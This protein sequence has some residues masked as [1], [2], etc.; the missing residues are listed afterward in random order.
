MNDLTAEDGRLLALARDGHEPTDVD[1]GRMRARLVAELGVGTGFVVT[2]AATSTSAA[3]AGT[4]GALSSG[5]AGAGIA[6]G[7]SFA[8][9]GAPAT[10]A[11]AKVISIILLGT[12]VGGGGVATYHAVS[13]RR[14]GESSR[15][16]MQ[17]LGTAHARRINPPGRADQP[18]TRAN[19][20]EALAQRTFAARATAGDPPPARAA[21]VVT[22]RSETTTSRTA[23]DDAPASPRDAPVS[24]PDAPVSTPEVSL[25]PPPAF[26]P[27]FVPARELSLPPPQ[28]SVPARKADA[29]PTRPPSVLESERRLVKGGLAALHAGDA[30]RALTLFDQHERDYPDGLFAE[31]RGAE[32]IVSLCELGRKS[33]ARAAARAFLRDHDRSPLAARVRAS[34]G[35]PSYP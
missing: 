19:A 23:P 7:G 32:R 9:S 14:A 21:R 1:R 24:T 16:A 10:L 3:A 25:A 20:A 12:V 35:A 18:L 28:V 30:A 6:A 31:E 11:V 22:I 27:A 5:G 29:S 8:L 17:S 2:A 13:A 4:A 26:V 34:C 33:D 15:P